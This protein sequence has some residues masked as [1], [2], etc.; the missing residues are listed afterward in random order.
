MTIG[1]VAATVTYCGAAPGLI[2][3]Q[4]NFTYPA[5]VPSGAPVRAVLTVTNPTG[6]VLTLATGRFWLP[7]PTPPTAAQQAGHM[8]AQMT[9]AQKLQLVAGAGG[10]PSN[11]IPALPIGAGG[12]IPGIPRWAFRLCT[13]SMAAWAWRIVEAVNG[14]AFFDRQ[15]RHLGPEPGVSVR[16]GDRRRD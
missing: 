5:G 2:N 9:Q 1:G 11:D 3:D 12:Y 14:A 8:L 10:T 7:A 6:R 16:N 15:R 13:L 4:L